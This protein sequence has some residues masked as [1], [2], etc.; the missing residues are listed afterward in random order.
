MTAEKPPIKNYTHLLFDADGTLFDYATAESAAIAQNFA[1]HGL[2]FW[3]E[4]GER[5]KIINH[6]FWQ[7]FEQGQTTAVELRTGRFQA[8]FDEFGIR[9]DVVAFAGTYLA[10]L[11]QQAQLISGADE[12]IAELHGRYHLTLIT[13]GLADVQYPRLQKS[14]LANYFQAVIVSDEIGVAKPD[15]AIFDFTFERLQRPAKENVLII[16]DG[17][18]SDMAGG[19][20]YGI[21][22]CWYNPHGKTA[23]LDLTYE[24][25]DLSQLRNIL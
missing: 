7:R 13:N 2:D 12:L 4:L 3:P 21:D 19:H 5:Y 24:I 15:P 22:T 9:Y 20:N 16:G 25:S 11:A 8:L 23:D 6:R 14:G 1:V 17:L 18:T 10:Q